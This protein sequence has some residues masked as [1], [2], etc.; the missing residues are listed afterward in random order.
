M[1]LVPLG[2]LAVSPKIKISLD[3]RQLD[4]TP[5]LLAHSQGE[6]GQLRT[7]EEMFDHIGDVCNYERRVCSFHD[8]LLGRL[9][10]ATNPGRTKTV[11]AYTDE[12]T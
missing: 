12:L 1:N 4:A 10:I 5:L 3:S 6:G 11:I 9:R 7:A 2:Q 8:T